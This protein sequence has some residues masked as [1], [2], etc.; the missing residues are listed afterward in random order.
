MRHDQ[1]GPF[2]GGQESFQPFHRLDVEVVG[3]L[4]QHEQVGLF[5]QQASQQ[6]AG[7]LPATEVVEGH[8]PVRFAQPKAV[9]GLLNAQVEFVTAVALEGVL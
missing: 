7:F 8:V 4:V 3:G 6:R 9:E 1:H 5:Q 2:P